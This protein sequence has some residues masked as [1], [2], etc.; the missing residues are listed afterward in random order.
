MDNDK[1]LQNPLSI[2]S[3]EGVQN[4]V[5]I[6][7]GMMKAKDLISGTAVDHYNSKLS[8][9]DPNQ[10]YQRPPERSRI[11]KIGS[12]LIEKILD[13]NGLN[14]GIFP[15]AVVLSSRTPLRFANGV[16]QV[17]NRLQIID[18]Q[19]RIAGLRY[20]IEEKQEMKLEE[21][22]V[23]FVV[24]EISDKIAEMNQFN[25]IN[26]TAKSVRTDLVNAILTATA[27]SR[28]DD[29]LAS[30]D[31]WKVV[32]TRVVEKLSTDPNSPWKGQIL[33]PDIAGSPKSNSKEIVR[34]TS[35]MTSLKPV[36]TWFESTGNF[37]TVKST[38]EE[39]NIMYETIANYWEALKTVVPE[40]FEN[41][42]NYVIQKTPGLFSL[43]KIL[44]MHF[45]KTMFAAYQPR[46]VDNFKLYLT[47]STEICDPHFWHKSEGRASAYGSMKG[48]DDLSKL[49]LMAY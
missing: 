48:F 31:R 41:P 30:K 24:L 40:A 42:Q 29:T 49:L 37:A 18:G 14:G 27:A 45:L 46:T 32:V 10:G 15:T 36:Y 1:N 7:T 43:H 22:P 33:M 3:I 13:G 44:Q 39:A 8:A 35:F 26:S 25:V 4:G 12:Y 11:T 19:H 9:D 38:Q 6:F 28:G 47:Q 21:F 2:R 23:P 5:R 20:A 34:A 16:L 17:T